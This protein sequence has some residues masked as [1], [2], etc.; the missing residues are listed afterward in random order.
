MDLLK[1]ADD[2]RYAGRFDEARTKLEE[3]RRRF[4]GTGAAAKASFELGRIAFDV[5]KNFAAAGDRFDTYLRERP[6]GSLAREALGRALEA[7][8][9]A[10]DPRSAGLAARYLAA[11]P[12]GPHA[13]LARRLARE[14]AP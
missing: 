4:P 8:S 11:Y 6:S 9:R 5:D 3:V 2:A 10:G 1:E 14:G 7:R 13:A 12:D